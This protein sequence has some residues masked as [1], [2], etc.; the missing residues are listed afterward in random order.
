VFD[1]RYHALSLAAVFVALVVGLLLGVA[2]GDQELVS[3]AQDK[4]R[5]NLRADIRKAQQ[6]AGDLRTDLDRRQRYEEATFGPLVAERLEGRRVTLLFLDERSESIFEHVREA[7]AP[8]GGELSFSATVRV[9]LDLEGIAGSA[10]GTQYEQIAQD[11]DL[12]DDLGRR[13]GVQLVQGGRLLREL[14][15]PL[16]ASSSGELGPTEAVVVVRTPGE[17][18]DDPADRD[19]ADALWR[20][21]IDGLREQRVPVV[22]VEEVST[23]P[24]QIPW[25]RERGIASVDN[26]DQIAGRAS[27]VY[28]LAGAADGAY[29]VKRTRD[30]LIPDALVRSP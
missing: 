7:V 26:V 29:G 9:P 3:S 16:L 12:I 4:L 17:R 23:E 6:E 22:G 15:E 28:A 10:A 14:K 18:L 11:G 8:S 30:A 19:R 27:L 25:Y 20:G 21:I 13:V 1:F 5:D 24:S 2:I